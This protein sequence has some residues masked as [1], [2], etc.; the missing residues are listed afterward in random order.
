MNK[1]GK[2]ISMSFCVSMVLGSQLVAAQNSQN[3]TVLE[4]IKV[5][6]NKVDLGSTTENTGSYTT[7][8]TSTATKLDLSLRETPQSV[9][10]VTTEQIQDQNLE[11]LADVTNTVAGFNSP[12]WDTDRVYITSRGFEVDYYQLDGIPTNYSGD[13]QQDLSMYDRVEI[14]K[15]ANGLMTGAGSP[16]ASINLVRK[17]AN[18]KEFTGNATISA[19][20]WD[21]YKGTVDI[22]TPVNEKGSVRTRVVAK[23]GDEDSFLNYYNKETTVLYGIVDADIS[24]DTKVFIGAS[25]QK[26]DASGSTWGG[27]PAWFSDGSDTNFS[28]STSITP[29]WT[30]WNKETNTIFTG[31]EHYFKNDVKVNANY[32]YLEFDSN[33][34]LTILG[35]G[36]FPDKI[37]GKG[38]SSNYVWKGKTK[39]KNHNIDIYSSIPIELAK[40]DHEIII[41]L[42]YNQNKSVSK[43]ASVLS[44]TAFDNDVLNNNVYNWN[45]NIR[46]PIW[47]DYSKTADNKT[48][49]TSVYLVSRLSLTDSLTM[50]LGSRLTDYEYN[51]ILSNYG[52]EYE[53]EI[54]PYA[55]LVYKLDDNHSIYTSYTNIFDP[56]ENKDQSGKY[57]D[58]KKGNS[59]EVGIKG[60]YFDKKLNTSLTLFR[61]EQ[62]NV[63]EKAGVNPTTLEDYYKGVDGTTSKGIEVDVRGEITDNWNAALSLVSFEAKDSDDRDVSTTAPRNQ[64]ILSSKYK[65]GK[66]SFG[67]TVN[68]QD[69]FYSNVTNPLGDSIKLTQNDVIIVNL[70]AKYEITKN[71]S[72]QLN[73]NNL[74]DK[75]YYSN[76]VYDM[77][78]IYGDPR[79]TTLSLNYKF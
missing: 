15:G 38:I 18:S 3:T 6:E 53:H 35:Y 8:A 56:Q 66:Y 16:A 67:G 54:T 71:L 29:D 75:N 20:S 70:M 26:N 77:Q 46:E 28:R 62:D 72:T 2:I 17:H 44:Q 73:I 79:N 33:S 27:V 74:F 42:S 14:V 19:G 1:K 55:G 37:T 51:N 22:S 57:L 49:Q 48:E 32:S 50:I 25:H 30:Y 52:F 45:S 63:A 12:V 65:F 39:D 59:Y 24:D 21:A 10:V 40:K 31:I 11:S 64:V 5:S 41:G 9:V 47:G 69:K 68:W 23:Y 60:E 78:Y 61:M 43:T 4:E 76:I 36:V 13:V 58:P 34:N 7:G